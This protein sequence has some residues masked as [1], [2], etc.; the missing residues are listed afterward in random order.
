MQFIVLQI[1]AAINVQMM[2]GCVKKFIVHWKKRN[3]C[4]IDSDE[5]SI[6]GQLLDLT[7]FGIWSAAG[8]LDLDATSGNLDILH[9]I[10]QSTSTAQFNKKTRQK[11]LKVTISLAKDESSLIFR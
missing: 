2:I 4:T 7:V 11:V 8:K 6:N 9:N 5:R 1:D 3:L 10:A